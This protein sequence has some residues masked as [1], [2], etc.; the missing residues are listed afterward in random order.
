MTD[1]KIY[2]IRIFPSIIY[3]GEKKGKVLYTYNEN[4][5]ENYYVFKA[6]TE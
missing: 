1:E 4:I 2:Y 6:H 3:S 5:T